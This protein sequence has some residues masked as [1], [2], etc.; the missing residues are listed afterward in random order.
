MKYFLAVVLLFV[1]VGAVAAEVPH[2]ISFQ[3]RLTTATGDTVTGNHDLTFKLYDASSTELW[4]ETHHDVPIVAGLYNVMLGSE[5]PFPAAVDFSEQ[6]YLGVT[7]DGGTEMTPRYELGASP[8]ALNLQSMGASDG[9]VLIWNAT[10][11]KWVPRDAPSHWSYHPDYINPNG[12]PNLKV[13]RADREYGIYLHVDDDDPSADS[14]RHGIYVYREDS[15]LG[16]YRPGEG[17]GYD[18]A[19]AN[20][21]AYDFDAAKYNFAIAGWSYLDDDTSAAV[22]GGNNDGSVYG[23]LGMRM[24]DH[25]YA[26]YFKG[27]VHITGDLTVDGSYPGGGGSSQWTDG[28]TYIYANNNNDVMVSDNTQSEGIRVE[29]YNSPADACGIAVYENYPTYYSLAKLGWYSADAGLGSAPGN[30]AVYAE[31]PSSGAGG[32][33]IHAVNNNASGYA[34]YFEG[35]VQITGKVG[36]GTSTPSKK[37]EVNGDAKVTE[38]L[39]VRDIYSEGYGGDLMWGN[40]YFA[41]NGVAIDSANWSGYYVGAAMGANGSGAFHVRKAYHNGLVIEEASDTGVVVRT[42]PDVGVYA[43]AS[44]IGIIGTRGG[45]WVDY[46]GGDAN[47]FKKDSLTYAGVTGHG[48]SYIGVQGYSRW[49]HGGLFKTTSSSYAGVVAVN[50]SG[51]SGSEAGLFYTKYGS[52]AGDTIKTHI[53][54]RSGGGTSYGILSNGTKSTIMPT[55]EG[56]RILYCPESPEVWFEDYGRG[57]LVNGRAHITLDKLFRET[58]TIDSAHPMEVFLQPRGDCNGL[59]WVPANDGFDVIELAGGTSNAEF[60]YKILAKRKGMEDNRFEKFEEQAPPPKPER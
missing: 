53:S 2:L 51:Y 17:F 48:S 32:N 26:G 8:Y 6:Y 21:G 20:I 3:G 31:I 15:E 5:T 24:D 36:I 27:D 14:T 40:G 30:C 28:G 1:F 46:V 43:T 19:L 59:Y 22:F 50:A 29:Y 11:S 37:L 54:Y 57:Q 58:V 52:N 34:G 35:D 7:L 49:D 44:Y 10:L 39:T 45:A 56:Q 4:S 13:Y 41:H 42:G 12:N 55:S 47:W 60:S 16:T 25:D 33:A 9:Q 38:R 23:A 18:E